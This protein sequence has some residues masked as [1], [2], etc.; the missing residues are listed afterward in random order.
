MN[1]FAL[2]LA[3][4]GVPGGV[5]AIPVGPDAAAARFEDRP[6]WLYRGHAIVGLPLDTDAGR[7]ELVVRHADGSSHR[8][9]FDVTAKEYPVQRLTIANPRHVNP[10]PE[11][12]KRYRR[13][14]ALM[15]YAY[16]VVGPR[17]GDPHPFVR[18]VPGVVSSPFGR[19][20]VLNGE[21]RSPHSGLDIAA[22]Q[23][24]PI[25]TPAAGRVLVTGDFFFNGNTVMVDHG[26]GLVTMYCHLHEIHVEEGQVL[27]RGGA[28][29]SVGAT[30]RSTGPHLHWTV[31][32]HGAK[33]D[34]D[35]FADTLARLAAGGG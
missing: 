6:A 30:G 9:S 10:N 13:E 15:G 5:V 25:R 14:A 33:V 19:R 21:P 8:A 31:S 7:Y 3:V 28:I 32:L 17:Q 27:P 18:P 35:V 12:L 26:E 4:A 34:P 22:D 20:R 16:G 24:T 29:G 23:G 2:V 11:D 1:L